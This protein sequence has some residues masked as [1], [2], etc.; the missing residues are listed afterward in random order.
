MRILLA[1]ERVETEE[2][3]HI[4]TVYFSNTLELLDMMV[5]NSWWKT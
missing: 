2:G 1:W 5:I 3:K 4:D